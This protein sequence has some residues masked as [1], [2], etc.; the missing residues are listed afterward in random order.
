MK[1]WERAVPLH[2]T[3]SADL[4]GHYT[5]LCGGAVTGRGACWVKGLLYH[6]DNT[7]KPQ[8]RGALIDNYG[9]LWLWES[10]IDDLCD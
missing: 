5:H 4:S 1:N 2:G 3:S 8:T 10:F 9:R 6:R 7:E